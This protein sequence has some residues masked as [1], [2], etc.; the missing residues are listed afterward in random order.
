MFLKDGVYDQRSKSKYMHTRHVN[1]IFPTEFTWS[2]ERNMS[3]TL[4]LI[5]AFNTMQSES[6]TNGRYEFFV[7]FENVFSLGIQI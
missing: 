3:V 4:P 5:L 6:T 2:Y 1:K 7:F